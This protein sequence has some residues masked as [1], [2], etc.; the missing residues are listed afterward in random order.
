MDLTKRNRVV[1][2]LAL[3]G[4]GVKSINA[5]QWS[6]AIRILGEQIREE[7]LASGKKQSDTLDLLNVSVSRKGKHNG[8]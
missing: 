8:V 2:N 3:R 5:A 4:N 1:R 6:E 7:L